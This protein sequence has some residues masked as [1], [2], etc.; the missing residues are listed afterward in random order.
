MRSSDFCR[1]LVVHLHLWDSNP[2]IWVGEERHQLFRGDPSVHYLLWD[3]QALHLHFSMF[4][5]PPM[6][7]TSAHY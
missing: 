6:R 2:W 7:L 3:I 1:L 5:L 4:V